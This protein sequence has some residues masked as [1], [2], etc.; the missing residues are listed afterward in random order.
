MSLLGVLM[1]TEAK[2][3]VAL[4]VFFS[5]GTNIIGVAT[6]PFFIDAIWSGSGTSAAAA[7]AFSPTDLLWKL[8]V[9]ILVPL[10]CGKVLQ[11]F[12]A[13]SGF[14][15][16]HKIPLKLLSSILLIIVPWTIM[17]QSSAQLHAMG[18]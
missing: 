3:N 11:Y 1:T 16:R 17:S 10:A 9:S 15:K 6:V 8:T 4:A 12:S 13:V 5:A 7:E 2:G 14:V 18:M